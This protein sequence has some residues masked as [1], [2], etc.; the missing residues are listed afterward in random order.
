MYAITQSTYGTPDVLTAV[1]RPAPALPDDGVRIAVEASAITQ[2][3]RRLRSGDFPGITWLPGRIAV[4]LTGPR[5]QPGFCFA[6]HV[7]EVGRAVTQW[8]VGDA[9]FGGAPGAW[10]DQL[11]L[12]E[13]GPFARMPDGWTAGEAADLAYGAATALHF[14]VDVAQV[15]PGERVCVLGASG[16]VGR[17]VVQLAHHMGAQVT[18]VCSARTHGLVTALGATATVDYRAQDFRTVAATE[19][20]FDVVID[21]M[22]ASSYAA[23]RHALTPTGRFATLMAS[24]RSLWDMAATALMGRQ[25]AA[26]SVAL[27]SP[28]AFEA[29]RALADD[30]ALRPVIDRTFPIDQIREAHA[31]VEAGG[32][33]GAVVIEV[34]AAPLRL[35][36]LRTA[37]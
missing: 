24:A 28:A 5:A 37:S 36:P 18:A 33:H 9:V 4:G 30:G 1:D 22:G 27:P 6:G 20:H 8:S 2:G 17:A 23:C 31:H 25:R 7:V 35:A 29:V 11:V 26:V 19:G 15:Q 21:T 34:S 3:D 32:V 16:G 12:P 14:L 13:D 10:A